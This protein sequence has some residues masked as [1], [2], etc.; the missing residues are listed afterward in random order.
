MGSFLPSD[1]DTAFK[2]MLWLISEAMSVAKKDPEL[3]PIYEKSVG[4]IRVLRGD[5]NLSSSFHFDVV[6]DSNRKIIAIKVYDKILDL[7]GREGVKAVSSRLNIVMGAKH[8]IGHL[9]HLIKKAKDQ[10]LSRLE[11]SLYPNDHYDMV[12]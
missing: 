8:S 2:T 10:G 1:P 12:I 7:I 3:Y 6:D 9:E 11:I 4:G 5:N